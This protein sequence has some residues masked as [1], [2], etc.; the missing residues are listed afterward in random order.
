MKLIVAVSTYNQERFIGR[1]IESVL[2]QKVNFDYEIVIGEDN[3]GDGTRDIVL[4]FHRR[5]PS[6]IVPLLGDRNLGAMRNFK[7][8]LAVC[9]GKYVA[10]LEGDDYWTHQDKLH[11]QTDFLDAHPEYTVCCARAQL[12]DETGRG[13]SA[14]HPTIPSGSYTIA[15]LFETNWLATC[16]V[17]YRWGSVGPL[18]DWVLNLKMGDWP[19]HILVGRSGKIRLMDEVMGVYRIHPAGAWSSLFRVDQLL[20]TREMFITL[21]KHLNFQDTETIRRPLA[22]IGLDLA[23]LHAPVAKTTARKRRITISPACAAAACT[24]QVATASSQGWQTTSSSAHGIRYSRGR[25]KQHAANGP[26]NP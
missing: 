19:L 14:I 1:A 25:R 26:P 21:R 4:Y 3:S 15:D 17:M 24:F 18:P 6:R 10:L 16:T 11:T 13:Y 12:L 2:A 8:A 7:E 23:A 9:R 22:R 5:Y 20:A